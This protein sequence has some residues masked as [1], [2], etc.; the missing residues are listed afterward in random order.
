MAVTRLEPAAVDGAADCC[1][2]LV[3]ISSYLNLCRC[4][5]DERIDEMLKDAL[6]DAIYARTE[7]RSKHFR[8]YVHT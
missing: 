5:E 2:I 1:R 7:V 3:A 4:V 8:S 6:E